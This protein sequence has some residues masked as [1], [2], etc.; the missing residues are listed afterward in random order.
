MTDPINLQA[1][2]DNLN[3]YFM[4]KSPSFADGELN[5]L[6]EMKFSNNFA[7]Y[8]TFQTNELL[9]V[10]VKIKADSER[11]EKMPAKMKEMLVSL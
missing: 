3:H 7:K 4:Q 1:I 11:I 5:Q 9:V 2:M 6:L 8:P 10:D